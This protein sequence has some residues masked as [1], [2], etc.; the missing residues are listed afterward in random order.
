M[1]TRHALKDQ[2]WHYEEYEKSIHYFNA[3]KTNS[4]YKINKRVIMPFYQD[5]YSQDWDR[6]GYSQAK[7]LRDIETVMRYFKPSSFSNPI[8]KACEEA[9]KIGQN[10]KIETDYFFIS[11][12]KKGTIHLE[13][14][15]DDLLRRFNIE[16][17]KM[18]N[19]IPK[20]YA[21]KDY[22]DLNS[23][24]KE[25]VNQF[26]GTGTYAPIKD[27]IRLT[28]SQNILALEHRLSA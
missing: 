8:D 1:M 21:D 18:K 23:E 5:Y 27:N 11:I 16:A 14:K 4:G 24:E 15:D 13:F 7:M 17:C 2:S 10:R 6:I 22:N 3:W 28:G 20:E 12:F 25:I 9:L 19:F 26:E